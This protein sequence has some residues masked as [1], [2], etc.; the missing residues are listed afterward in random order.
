MSVCED[1]AKENLLNRIEPDY[2]E[3]AREQRLQGTVILNINVG[4]DGAVHSLS[5]SCR[6][7][8][9]CSALCPSGST[10]EIYSA[11]SGRCFG[12]F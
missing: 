8:P 3:E 5:A 1:I 6:R 11:G 10:V 9:A 7:F 12:K 2:P 4:K